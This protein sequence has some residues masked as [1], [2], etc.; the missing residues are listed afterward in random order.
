MRRRVGNGSR[1]PWTS[2]E[3]NI[4]VDVQDFFYRRSTYGAT[5]GLIDNV[6]IFNRLGCFVL[7]VWVV[8]VS[9]GFDDIIKFVFHCRHFGKYE[10]RSEVRIEGLIYVLNKI[11]M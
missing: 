9:T 8:Y 4:N 5:D 10:V 1:S 3:Q 2:R 6:N 7:C 11:E